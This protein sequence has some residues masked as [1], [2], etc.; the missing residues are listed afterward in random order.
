MYC[1]SIPIEK[2]CIPPKNS[3][4]L[5]VEAHPLTASPNRRVLMII[6]IMNITAKMEKTIP[7]I[8][9]MYNGVVENDVIPSIA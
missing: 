8:V 9:D 4:T 5:M 7:I 1:P 3:I 6:I 2:S